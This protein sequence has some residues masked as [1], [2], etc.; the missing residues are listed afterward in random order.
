V[1]EVGAT[2]PESAPRRPGWNRCSVTEHTIGTAPNASQILLVVIYSPTSA[3]PSRSRKVQSRSRGGLN[4]GSRRLVLRW[5]DRSRRKCADSRNGGSSTPRSGPDDIQD[6]STSHPLRT[7]LRRNLGQR[8][9]RR[10]ERFGM[11]RSLTYN[12]TPRTHRN[13]GSVSP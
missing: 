2:S 11:S 6:R 8:A 12:G 13:G 5:R 1:I 7:Q 10:P 3:A 4:F 9:G